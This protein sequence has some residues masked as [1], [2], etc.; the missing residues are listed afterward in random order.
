MQVRPAPDISHCDVWSIMRCM[1]S[2]HHN[3]LNGLLGTM[4]L[5]VTNIERYGMISPQPQGA[6]EAVILPGGYLRRRGTVCTMK[7]AKEG[8][9]TEVWDRFLV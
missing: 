8:G 6:A 7:I 3:H 5:T 4:T 2:D 1:P 9:R